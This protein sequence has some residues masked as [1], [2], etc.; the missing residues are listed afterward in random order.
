MVISIVANAVP[1]AVLQLAVL[2]LLAGK[3]DANTYGLVVTL[4]SFFSFCP[5]T[6]G[7]VITNVRLIR[8]NDYKD[9][10][11]SGD[12]NVLVLFAMV[13]AI[14]ATTV[15]SSFVACLNVADILLVNITSVLWTVQSYWIVAFRLDLNYFSILINNIVMS[16]GYVVGYLAYTAGCAWECVY[17]VGQLFSVV[18]LLRVT[19]VWREPCVRTKLFPSVAKE[20]LLLTVSGLLSRTS[21]YCDRIVLF[22]LLGGT[23]VSV[24]Y[25][26]TLFAKIISF[27]TSAIN[28]VIL[29]Y[30]SR[31]RDEQRR[32][33]WLSLLVGAVV[34]LVS[35]FVVLAVS[36]AL[37]QILYPQFV[38][39]ALVYVPVTSATAFIVVLTNIANPYVLRFY[40]MEWQMMFSGVSAAVY[41]ASAFVLTGLF[42]LL[43]FCWGALV[44]EIIRLALTVGVFC[45]AP[46]KIS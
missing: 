9:A 22:P 30:L 37:L 17:L 13:I 42:G 1:L 20:S 23:S 33:F 40:S 7:N 25:V 8:N 21:T 45:F 16:L 3:L 39:E 11:I 5:A 36:P 34:C 35:Y 14:V 38:Q 19:N 28:N 6:F 44:A 10:E 15:Y 18:H 29:S 12:F 32:M 27:A 24:Y 2:P 41:L 4:A 26:S 43:G 31:A 46:K